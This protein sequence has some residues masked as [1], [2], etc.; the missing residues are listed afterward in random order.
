MSVVGIPLSQWNLQELRAK[1]AVVVQDAL[2]KYGQGRTVIVM[3]HRLS[4]IVG[5]DRVIVFDR[6]RI[7]ETGTHQELL[8]QRGIYFNLYE[9]QWTTTEERQAV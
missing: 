3:A 8:A 9:T 4:T 2:V 6:G 1:V 7:A 5:A